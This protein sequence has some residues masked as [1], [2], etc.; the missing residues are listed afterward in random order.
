MIIHRRLIS[1][2]DFHDGIHGFRVGRGTSTAII[3][4]K[5]RM[6]L[7]KRRKDPLYYIFLDVKKAYD[8]LDRERTLQLLS[9]YGV[10][11]NICRLLHN[12]W[13]D[14]T[15]VPKQQQF[16]GK[17][18]TAERGVRQ[19]DIV[20]PTIFNIVVDAVVRHAYHKVR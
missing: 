8:S 2:I 6:Q 16:Y 17:A 11:A 13:Q 3:N 19:G 12:M 10:G 9:K 4:I 14:D 7:A 18:F 20:S 15:I 5:L 1:S